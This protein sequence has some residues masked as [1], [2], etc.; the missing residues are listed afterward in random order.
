[1]NI[2]ITAAKQFGPIATVITIL[3][4][5]VAKVTRLFDAMEKRIERLENRMDTIHDGCHIPRSAVKEI[6]KRL[7]SLEKKD[8]TIDV[9]LKGISTTLT[10]V[11]AMTSR[12]F[13]HFFDEGIKQGRRAS[14]P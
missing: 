14:D 2:L 11:E 3:I 1:M 4:V 6:N 10:R 13:N 9:E 7:D 5:F 8:K 12:I